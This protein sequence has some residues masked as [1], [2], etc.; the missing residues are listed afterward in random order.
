MHTITIDDISVLKQPEDSRLC[1]RADATGHKV[2]LYFK[3][4]ALVTLASTDDPDTIDSRSP[5]I[6]NSATHVED[7]PLQHAADEL[8]GCDEIRD[9]IA[10]WDA[11]ASL[12]DPGPQ[13]KWQLPYP[14]E[15][16]DLPEA[17]LMYGPQR[18]GK[19]MLKEDRETVVAWHTDFGA[20]DHSQGFGSD[21]LSVLWREAGEWL[22]EQLPYALRDEPEEPEK[23][24]DDA[25]LNRSR[26]AL[27][28][29]TK[30]LIANLVAELYEDNARIGKFFPQ[31]P[32]MLD[33]DEWE[34]VLV[35]RHQCMLVRIEDMRPEGT[36][37]HYVSHTV[38]SRA[39]D[40]SSDGSS[41]FVDVLFARRRQESTTN[42]E[43][44][45][46]PNPRRNPEPMSQMTTEGEGIARARNLL[47]DNQSRLIECVPKQLD[48]DRLFQVYMTAIRTTPRLGQCGW[49]S[50][51]PEE[52]G[53]I[54]LL[55]H[56]LMR[57]D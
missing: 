39:D 48:R 4:C 43:T 24:P 56:A 44:P 16:T 10:L 31:P 55:G 30:E 6:D 34:V 35:T 41:W 8:L 47:L 2:T 57:R 12:P 11:R 27:N 29:A 38:S 13:L 37:W 33:L 36:G 26:P 51:R 15:A 21:E 40:V 3:D 19:V 28:R 49:R 54:E 50:C 46:N 20:M 42:Q 14:K 22:L 17:Q 45:R 9:Y 7:P 1:W 5:L 18:V 32:P 53:A 52:A 23:S 25:V